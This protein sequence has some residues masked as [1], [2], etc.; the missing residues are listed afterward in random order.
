MK[1]YIDKDV[2]IYTDAEANERLAQDNDAGYL[3]E[4]QGIIQVPVERWKIAQHAERIHWM[5]HGL[6]TA[7]DRNY[8]HAEQ[9][10][11][12][13]A[14]RGKRFDHAI[15]LGCGPFTNMRIIAQLCDVGRCTLLD[16]LID[17]YLTHPNRAYDQQ[18][19]FPP[20]INW[21]AGYRSVYR[22]LRARLRA[23]HAP[24]KV[25]IQALLAT[26]IETMPTNATYDLVVIINVI[27][28][29]YD[30]NQV[31][32]N[33]LAITQPGSLLVFHDKYYHH[34]EVA[35]NATRTYDAAHPLRVDFALIEQFLGEHFEP[36]YRKDRQHSMELLGETMEWRGAYYIGRR[37]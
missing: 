2:N 28:H 34:D 31:F 11:N 12:Y 30:M 24:A 1:F 19:L 23:A 13:Q 5:D 33:L 10:A 36:V 35:E 6:T 25:P 7:D 18:W 22:M 21:Q 9:F 3:S 8:D 29:C 27:E 37:V 14:L 4:G 20:K 17:S 26:P 16:P 15:E 32:Q